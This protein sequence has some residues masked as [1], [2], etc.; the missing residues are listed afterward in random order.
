MV[1]KYILQANSKKG[2]TYDGL[3]S[4]LGYSKPGLYLAVK[5]AEESGLVTVIKTGKGPGAKNIIYP[6]VE[7]SWED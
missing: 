7:L 4:V 5:K 6:A 1:L 3:S 2:A